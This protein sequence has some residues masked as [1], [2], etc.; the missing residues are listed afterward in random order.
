MTINFRSHFLEYKKEEWILTTA[1]DKLERENP[2]ADGIYPQRKQTWKRG[3]L[4]KARI[5]LLLLKKSTGQRRFGCCSDPQVIGAEAGKQGISVGTS[6]PGTL[7]W[8]AR[9]HPRLAN[10]KPWLR[11]TRNSAS[12]N[13]ARE[14]VHKRGKSSTRGTASQKLV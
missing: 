8:G 12:G 7:F 3:P 6:K 10:C 9:K 4:P 14:A 5:Q 13:S 11:L 2:G 1:E